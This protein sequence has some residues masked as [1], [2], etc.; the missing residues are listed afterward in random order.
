MTTEEH[1]ELDMAIANALGWTEL[2]HRYGVPPGE[3]RP[4]QVPN[5]TTSNA[6]AMDAI[7]SLGQPFEIEY[8]PV[9]ESG[10]IWTVRLLLIA[11]GY[12]S[13]LSV[14]IC[15]AVLNYKQVIGAWE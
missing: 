6:Y 10:L 15:R 7:L 5:Y 11:V 2:D 12:G 1:D 3:N 8:D 13:D 4:H 9:E 14:A